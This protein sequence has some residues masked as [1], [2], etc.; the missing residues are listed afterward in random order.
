M[1]IFMKVFFKTNLFIWFSHF[2]T[3]QHNLKVIHDLYSQNVGLKPYPKRLSL[4][5]GG[6]IC[7]FLSIRKDL[8]Y[9][10]RSKL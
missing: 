4:W 9:S 1:Y 7:L 5:Y 8:L 6:G 2:Q 3:Q 10:L